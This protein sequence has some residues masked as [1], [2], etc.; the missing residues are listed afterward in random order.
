MT[1]SDLP[2]PARLDGARIL[3]TAPHFFGYD[4]EIVAE[5]ERRGA[6]VD[7]VPDRPFDAPLLKAAARFSRA[8]VLRHTRKVWRSAL[9]GFGDVQ[10]DYVLIINGQTLPEDILADL[11]ARQKG[12]AFLFYIWDSLENRGS[13]LKLLKYFDRTSSFEIDAAHANGMRF[14]PLFFAP[15]F[16]LSAAD[17][18]PEI[19][20][21]IS[22]LGTAHSDRYAI[23]KSIDARLPADIRRRWFLYLQAR[24]V[25]SAYRITNP[26]FRGADADD[27]SF[28]PMGREDAKAIFWAS[29]TI[30]D[31]EH[32]RQKGLTIRTFETLGA[33]RKLVTT[34]AEIRRYAF[35]DPELVQVIDRAAPV[36]D[37]G[38][39]ATPAP[40][41]DADLYQR[42]SVAGFVDELFDPVDRSASHLREAA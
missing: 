8:A 39:L 6:H 21:D 38:F 2:P 11:R 36:V 41:L 26:G 9:E 19:R 25:L 24:W 20:H 17:E 12:A 27:F 18:A 40:E 22:F 13:A 4:R 30:L 14:R 16:A 33:R 28:E 34:N 37:P 23:V 7:Y 5:L 3:M 35:Y 29:R 42:Y 31:I 15:S 32:P 1:Q 10:Y